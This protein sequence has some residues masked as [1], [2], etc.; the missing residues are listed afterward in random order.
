MLL[1]LSSKNC[2]LEQ[3]DHRFARGLRVAT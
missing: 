1:E 3:V 2:R